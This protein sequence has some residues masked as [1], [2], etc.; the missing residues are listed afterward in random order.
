M[1]VGIIAA[2]YGKRRRNAQAVRAESVAALRQRLERV[3]EARVRPRGGPR[4]WVCRAT[5]SR[6]PR[7]TSRGVWRS[8]ARAHGV[9]SRGETRCRRSGQ[10]LELDFSVQAPC[11]EASAA[12]NAGATGR[13]AARAGR[14]RRRRGAWA[15]RRTSGVEEGRR[16][17]REGG[18]KGRIRGRARRRARA[19]ARVCASVEQRESRRGR[20]E[21]RRTARGVLRREETG[22]FGRQ[23]VQCRV[24]GNGRRETRT[25]WTWAFSEKW[26]E[27]MSRSSS[28]RVVVRV[29]DHYD[30]ET[31]TKAA[32]F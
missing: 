19:R 31:R 22:V 27:S 32:W 24:L 10:G 23:S 16:R 12:S 25:I 2:V 17:A 8:S 18:R 11:R 6:E 20:G 13:G 9:A 14:A 26:W 7:G 5:P 3:A 28:R 21:A 29:V 30:D 15:A 1:C 4:R